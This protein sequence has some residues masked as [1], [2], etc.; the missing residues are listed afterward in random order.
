MRHYHVLVGLPGYIPNTNYPCDT[1][2]QARLCAQE[3]KEAFLDSAAQGDN[4]DKLQVTGDIRRD[5]GYDVSRLGCYG[6]EVWQTIAI[7][8]CEEE[9]CYT[10]EGELYAE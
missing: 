7:S 1:L 3:E 9:D 8:E 2:G 6:R 10:E 5:W 4:E